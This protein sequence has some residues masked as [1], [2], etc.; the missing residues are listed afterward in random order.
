MDQRALQGAQRVYLHGAPR[1]TFS[2][3]GLHHALSQRPS[4]DG[5]SMTKVKN[6]CAKLA[7]LTLLVLAFQVAARGQEQQLHVLAFYSTDVERDHV[8]FAKQALQFFS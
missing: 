4:L 7:C 2:G 6:C 8:D 1:R 5:S 3:P